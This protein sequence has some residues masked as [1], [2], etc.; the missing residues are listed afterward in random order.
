[1][2]SPFTNGNCVVPNLTM[3]NVTWPQWVGI[4]PPPPT[5]D[6]CELGRQWGLKLGVLNQ[7]L[8]QQMQQNNTTVYFHTTDPSSGVLSIGVC[9]NSADALS[10]LP[11]MPPN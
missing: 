5:I 11:T 10:H 6:P 9:S 1:M 2:E 7:Q 3:P 8:V 4:Q